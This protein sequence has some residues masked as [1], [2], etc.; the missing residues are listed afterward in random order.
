MGKIDGKEWE[1]IGFM[2]RQ[3]TGYQY[4]WEE[5]LLYNPWYGFRWLVNNYGHWS[6]V[7]PMMDLPDYKIGYANGSYQGRSYKKF[8][9]GGAD[10]VF[11]LGEFYWRVKRG[12]SARTLDLVSPP[13]MLSYESDPNGKTWSIGKYME[14]K[15]V[16][17]IFGVKRMPVKLRVGAH[18]PNQYKKRFNQILPIAIIAIAIITALQ[19]YFTG[20]NKN[21]TV[22]SSGRYMLGKTDTTLVSSPF[23]ME[24]N[25]NVEVRMYCS[26]LDNNWAE[27]NGYLHNETTNENYGFKVAVEYWS[28]VDSDGAWTEGS[29]KGTTMINRVPEGTYRLVTNCYAGKPLFALEIFVRRD[30][31]FW[32]NWFIVLLILVIYPT[33]LGIMSSQFE[34][35]RWA[36]A[37]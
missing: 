9:S 1:V 13:Y 3:A 10:V 8:T 28:G 35:Q 27:F 17:E 37:D 36:E 18:Q 15:E 30:V 33:Y 24:G 20:Q 19:I 5:Y 12:D 6:F 32:T 22:Y 14:P 23:K 4:F 25:R 16:K 34:K 26:T 29:R 31:P 11:V 21:E 7:K 2:V